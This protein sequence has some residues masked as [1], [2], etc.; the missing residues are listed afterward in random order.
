MNYNALDNDL[1]KAYK[2]LAMLWH[3]NKN[4]TTKKSKVEAKFKQIVEAYYVLSDSQ[5]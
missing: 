4:L 1:N 5:K 3:L 2:R